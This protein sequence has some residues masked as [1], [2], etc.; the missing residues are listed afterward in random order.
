MKVLWYK[1]FSTLARVPCYVDFMLLLFP[2]C[3]RRVCVFTTISKHGMDFQIQGDCY[4]EVFIICY[5]GF[6]QLG[7]AE[8]DQSYKEI[9]ET[10]FIHCLPYLC[11]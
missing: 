11:L 3:N 10:W 2:C 4:R 6:F 9:N 7:S 8:N 1:L 5:Y